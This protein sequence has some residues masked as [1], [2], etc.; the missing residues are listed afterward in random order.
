MSKPLLQFVYDYVLNNNPMIKESDIV[1]YHL[2]N[3]Y[4]LLIKFKDGRNIIY[5]TYMNTSRPVKYTDDNLTDEQEAYEFR[6]NLRK[7][8]KHK[9]I[10]QTE[11]AKRVGV[12]QAMISKYITGQSI[13]NAMMLNKL[14]KALYCTTDAFFYKH[15]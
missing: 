12:S 2:L 9:R 1:E 3:E 11:L 13:P 5:D 14:A 10:D 6:I 7:L 15:Y 4:D 8:M